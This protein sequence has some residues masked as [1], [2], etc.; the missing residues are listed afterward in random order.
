M[1]RIVLFSG[2]IDS[3]VLLYSAVYAYEKDN[4]TALFFRYGQRHEK[5]FEA[6]YEMALDCQSELL[7]VDLDFSHIQ[8]TLLNEGSEIIGP[9]FVPGRNAIFLSYAAG[10]AVSKGIEGVMIGST[11]DDYADYPDCRPEFFAL[12]G[13]AMRTGVGLGFIEAPWANMTKAQ[14]INLGIP[15]MVPFAKTWTCYLG[16]DEPCMECNSCQLRIEA[17]EYNERD[18]YGR[19]LKAIA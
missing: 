10:I 4:V 9:G 3:A 11:K 5:E 7:I 1:K 8:S 18:Y 15:L 17:M 12:M 16:G 13:N 14:V 6:A 19:S 2:G